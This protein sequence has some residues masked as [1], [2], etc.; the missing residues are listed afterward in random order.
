MSDSFD[1]SYIVDGLGKNYTINESYLKPYPSC[2]HTHCPIEAIENIRKR[3][4][5]SNYSWEDIKSIRI[6]IYKNAIMVAGQV[7]HPENLEETKFSIHFTA[8]CTMV[9]GEFGLNEMNDYQ[10]S[11]INQLI[12][13]IELREDDTLEDTKKG[14]RGACVEVLLN[15]GTRYSSTVLVPKGET[16]NPMTLSDIEKKL[17]DAIYVSAIEDCVDNLKESVMSLEKISVFMGIN[18]LM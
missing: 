16:I 4:L 12:E 15:D 1:Q 10:D 18:S 7:I 5:E 14:I 9:K 6:K 11:G 13:K 3:M 8:A 2:R 17:N